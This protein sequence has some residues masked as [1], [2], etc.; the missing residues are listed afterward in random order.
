MPGMRGTGP[1]SAI[2]FA[3]ITGALALVLAVLLAVTWWRLVR[4]KQAGEA[5]ARLQKA[6]ENAAREWQLT[7]DAVES[8][9]LVVGL[10]GTIRRM[11]HA[12][13][14][15]AGKHYR[16]LLGRPVREIAAGEPWESAA[17]LVEVVGESREP[18]S[19]SAEDEAGHATWDLSATLSDDRIVVVARDVTGFVE[20]QRTLRRSEL[21]SAMGSLVAGVAH[22][23]R[24]P[25]FGISA[26]VDAFE[27]R[28]GGREEYR[29]YLEVLKTQLARLNTLMQEL[30]E[31]GKP[32]VLHLAPHE[33]AGVVAEA[34]ANCTSLSERQ[35]VAV[36]TAVEPSLPLVVLDRGRILQVLQNLL[37]NALQHS[38]RGSAVRIEVE[39]AGEGRE[40]WA[41]CRVMDAGPGF[42]EEDLPRVFEPFFT[43]RREGTGLG[44]SIVQRILEQH[45]G[46]IRAGNVPGGGAVMEIELPL[47][48]D[49]EG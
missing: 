24:N 42:Q 30:L 38:P 43:R 13:S 12:A 21:M 32:P 20:L 11:N 46:R 1:M 47:A 31:Y 29:R 25:L 8:S 35:G 37:E 40:R 27:N 2:E 16:E 5:G 33:L 39:P 49:R 44:L 19:C 15:L 18:H 34:V 26:V 45:G 41:R 48:S 17:V 3:G 6:I 14:R 4:L 36:E 7:F 9:L 23:V 28:F 22:E 10:D